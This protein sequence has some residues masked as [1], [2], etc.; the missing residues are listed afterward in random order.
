MVTPEHKAAGGHVIVRSCD[1]VAVTDNRCGLNGR[2]RATLQAERAK[3][4]KTAGLMWFGVTRHQAVQDPTKT[5]QRPCSD[6][7]TTQRRPTETPCATDA[8][9]RCI[10]ATVRF[11]HGG[12][13]SLHFVHE[14]SEVKN[15]NNSHLLQFVS[16]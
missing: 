9:W 8:V 14:I 11:R 3:R 12:A 6:L 13:A 5:Q 7:I 16:R 1:R 10:A 2:Q 4:L 15:P